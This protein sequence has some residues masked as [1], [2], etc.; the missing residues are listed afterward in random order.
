VSTFDIGQHLAA[1][2]GHPDRTAA[3]APTVLLCLP[4]RASTSRAV[5]HSE[6]AHRLRDG[7]GVSAAALCP[8]H[9]YAQ[10]GLHPF[11]QHLLVDPQPTIGPL[12]DCAGGPLG[13]LDF[14]HSAVFIADVAAD[15]HATWSQIVDGTPDAIPLSD[16]VHALAHDLP[17]AVAAYCAQPRISAMLAANQRGDAT[18]LPD[19]YG[20][21]LAAY[22][23]GRAEHRRYLI[24]VMQLG[25]ALLDLDGTL[26]APA[27]LHR[28]RLTHGLAQ[29]RAYHDEA[30]RR[31]RTAN[32]TTVLVACHI[33]VSPQ[34]SFP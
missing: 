7:L 2:V 28:P 3:A 32:P 12:H 20:P 29:C 5:L 27:P 6:V 30:R 24:D 26:I 22:Q 14:T 8:G 19:D 34:R 18:F 25:D 16:L 1:L 31:L 9:L 33:H 15:E 17:G 11:E 23:A 10:S 4:A 13:L 21:L